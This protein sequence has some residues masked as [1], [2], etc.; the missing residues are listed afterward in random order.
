MSFDSCADIIQPNRTQNREARAS[1]RLVQADRKE[2]NRRC[3][4]GER[5]S[6]LAQSILVER[7]AN[8][9]VHPQPVEGADFPLR[10]D[11]ARGND[12]M[13]RCATQLL[14]PF[15]IGATHS[16]FAIYIRAEKCG[17]ERFEL[18]DYIFCS[19][20]QFFSPTCGHD[21]ALGSVQRDDNCGAAHSRAKLSEK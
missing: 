7:H 18:L 5:L 16:S 19:N 12:R 20:R 8:R 9:G 10:L 2:R 13:R 21:S 3:W 17:A 14:E 1:N 6:A 11:A 4:T 15:E